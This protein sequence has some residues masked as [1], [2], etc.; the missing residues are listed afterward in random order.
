MFC[1]LKNILYICKRVKE[2]VLWI[3]NIGRLW[4][5][6]INHESG[7]KWIWISYL[8]LRLSQESSS[9]QAG[10]HW[11]LST[12]GNTVGKV[13]WWLSDTG[14]SV[15]VGTLIRIT[16][17]IVVRNMTSNHIIAEFNTM[18]ILKPKGMVVY[19]W[20]CYN[21]WFESTKVHI[22]KGSKSVEAGMTQRVV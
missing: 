3:K 5:I 10:Y 16:R 12:E 15:E 22:S 11:T 13:V 18:G 7:I 4:S 21:P 1:F 20:C 19:R 6:K 14:R 8:G 17:R 9:R 2:I